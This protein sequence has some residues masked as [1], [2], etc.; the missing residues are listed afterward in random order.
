MKRSI[1]AFL[2]FLFV[3]FFAS[4][5]AGGPKPASPDDCLVVIKSDFVQNPEMSETTQNGRDYEMVLSGDYAPIAVKRGYSL[6]VVREP[7]VK[8]TM[9]RGK[10]RPGWVGKPFE[11]RYDEVLPYDPGHLLIA[12]CVLVKESEKDKVENWFYTKLFFRKIT[13]QER[14]EL[15]ARFS[16]DK[17]F[18]AWQK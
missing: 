1:Y 15:L 7:A 4:G 13:D 12:D 6:V 2:A 18:S 10:L 9:I 14:A 8:V 3:A 16:S 11:L 17:S 5:C